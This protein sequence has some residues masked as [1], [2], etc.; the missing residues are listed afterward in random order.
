MASLAHQTADSVAKSLAIDV[1]V[2]FG[3]PVSFSQPARQTSR[4][5][6]S[7]FTRMFAIIAWTSWKEAIGRPNCSRSTA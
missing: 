4:R 6:A 5:A 3:W 1:S 7:V 2:V